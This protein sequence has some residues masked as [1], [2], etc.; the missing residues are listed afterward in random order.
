MNSSVRSPPERGCRSESG[1]QS[2]GSKWTAQGIQH[3]QHFAPVSIAECP[4]E[5]MRNGVLTQL[6]SLLFLMSQQAWLSMQASAPLMRWRRIVLMRTSVKTKPPALFL[7]CLHDAG[8]ARRKR[9]FRYEVRAPAS[10]LR[11]ASHLIGFSGWPSGGQTFQP[12]RRAG[13]A[14]LGSAWSLFMS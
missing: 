9:A 12:M 2:A 14:A 6:N 3:M 4:D 7:A 10:K 8:A 11:C 5:T 1:R 13:P